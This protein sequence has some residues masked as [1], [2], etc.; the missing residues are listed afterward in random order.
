[1]GS[2]RG[3]P[4]LVRGKS[5]EIVW[6]RAGTAAVA[7]VT[8]RTRSSAAGAIGFISA[9]AAWRNSEPSGA[10]ARMRCA[11]RSWLSLPRPAANPSSMWASFTPGRNGRTTLADGMPRFGVPGVG[12]S[13]STWAPSKIAAR[14]RVDGLTPTDLQAVL[15][16]VYSLLPETLCPNCQGAG[17]DPATG[18]PCRPCQQSGLHL[19]HPAI[20]ARWREHW[21]A[22]RR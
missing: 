11:R 7:K 12:G 9:R 13:W 15:Q 6:T 22:G 1:M 10:L 17:I 18:E 21:L 4:G 19:D 20:S 8:C 5:W 3:R 2:P 14:E 16:Q